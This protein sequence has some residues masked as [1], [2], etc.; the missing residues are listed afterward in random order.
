MR[1]TAYAIALFFIATCGVARADLVAGWTFEPSP[2][3]TAGPH[4]AD[5]GVNAGSGSPASGFHVSGATVYDNPVGNGTAES[6]SSNNWAVGDYYQFRTSTTGFQGVSLSFSATSSNT[7]PRDFQVQYSTNGTAFT[8]L[9]VG[10]TYSVL[11]NASPNLTW[12][13]T[14]VRPEYSFNFNL[15]AALDNQAS[16]FLRLVD[17]STVSANGMTVAAGGTSRI[18]T[19]MIN[20]AAV[21]EPGAVCFGL[22][23]CSVVG[24]GAAWRRYF[25]QQG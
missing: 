17:N 19:V 22:L 7:G 5:L 3:T 23:V 8:P 10:T 4:A 25:G 12:S 18:D 1:S 24:F 9:T 16:I 11:A 14:T 20:A 13:S 21:P 15:P 6:F 2:P